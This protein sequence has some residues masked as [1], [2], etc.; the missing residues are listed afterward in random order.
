MIIRDATIS[1]K[2]FIIKG[3][4]LI[5]EVS[6]V[7]RPSLLAENFEKDLFCEKPKF[8]CF[9]IEEDNQLVAYCIYSY[10]YWSDDGLG[11]YIS[12][13]FVSPEYRRRGYLKAIINHIKNNNPEAKFLTAFVGKENKIMQQAIESLGA[14]Q[15]NLYTYEMKC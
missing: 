2:D 15:T 10:V 11:I 12:N 3:N 1:D 13:I 14:T 7:T 8:N 9:V 4:K 5:D 6:G